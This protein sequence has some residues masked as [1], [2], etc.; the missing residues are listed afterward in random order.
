MDIDIDI[1]DDRWETLGLPAIAER[2]AIA[3][4]E[5]LDID[6][7]ECELSILGCGDDKIKE[8]NADF[9]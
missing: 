4:L 3:V 6:P 7:D 2:A 5:R 1:T 8:L 9:R